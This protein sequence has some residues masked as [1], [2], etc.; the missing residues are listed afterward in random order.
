MPTQKI[1]IG[2]ATGAFGLYIL[3]VGLALLPVPGGARNLHAPFWVAA[4]AGL[5]FL[6]G[7][8]SVLVQAIGRAND[9]AELP[10]DASSWMIV[11][12]YGSV[13]AICACLAAIGSWVAFAP[14]ERT[15]SGASSGETI[16]RVV[17][18]I[19]AVITWLMT[20]AFAIAAMRRFQRRRGENR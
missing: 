17:F 10:A 9:D 8:V 7:G 2:L 14:G 3:L 18:G 1:V 16:G 13:V 6:L 5:V 20:L 11:L 12:Q 15:F 19:G 4:L